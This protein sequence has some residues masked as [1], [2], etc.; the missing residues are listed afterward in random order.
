MKRGDE[1]RVTF[2]PGL[3]VPAGKETRNTPFSSYM[4]SFIYVLMGR[5]PV[6][7]SSSSA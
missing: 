2:R 5:I 4:E 1:N 7:A 3:M 6:A